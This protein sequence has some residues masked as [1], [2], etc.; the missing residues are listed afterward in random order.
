MGSDLF[1]A[2]NLIYM[3]TQTKIKSVWVKVKNVRFLILVSLFLLVNGCDDAKPT[4]QNTTDQINPA[5]TDTDS[6]AMNNTSTVAMPEIEIPHGYTILAEDQGDLDGDGIKE[7]AIVF[8]TDQSGENGTLREIQIYV[9]QEGTWS[10]WHTSVGAVLPSESGGTLG[11]PFE[12]IE[13]LDG[14][15]TIKHY[16]GSRDRWSFV[17]EFKYQNDAWEL[18]AATLVYSTACDYTETFTYN[19]T[20]K[21]GFHSLQQEECNGNG[22]TISS[23]MEV[24]ESLVIDG[25]NSAPLMDGFQPGGVKA[26]IKGVEEVYYY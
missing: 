14:A 19:L 15:I 2:T 3:K 18:I 6:S 12:N 1:N 24:E 20:K 23:H 26:T 4:E 11:D 21:T 8:N 22:E 10:L 9:N 25:K 7:R 17:H 13:I 5:L 16:G